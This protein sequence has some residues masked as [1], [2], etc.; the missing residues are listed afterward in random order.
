MQIIQTD[1]QFHLVHRLA[2]GFRCVLRGLAFVICVS[3]KDYPPFCPNLII[4]YITDLLVDQEVEM[5]FGGD[6][7]GG[8]SRFS[9]F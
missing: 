3:A 4:F 5:R 1:P 7:I 2:E 6:E 9:I 8:D